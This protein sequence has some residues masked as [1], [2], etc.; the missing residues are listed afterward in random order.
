M[1]Q[2]SDKV[3]RL[4]A[5]VAGFALLAGCLN[6]RSVALQPQP[7]ALTSPVAACREAAEAAGWKVVDV[8]DVVQVSDGYWEARFVVDDAEMRNLLGCRH[9]VAGGFTEVYVLEE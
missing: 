7:A 1:K 8:T 2:L 9:S 4:A 5:C 6:T 3:I